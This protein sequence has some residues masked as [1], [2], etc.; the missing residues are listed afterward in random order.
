MGERMKNMIKRLIKVWST[1]MLIGAVCSVSAGAEI[2]QEVNYDFSNHSFTVSGKTDDLLGEV[3]FQVLK[4]DSDEITDENLLYKDQITADGEGKFAFTVD[5]GDSQSGK[6]AGYIMSGDEEKILVNIII[7]EKEDYKRVIE[8]LKQN[9]SSASLMQKFIL[10]EDIDTGLKIYEVLGWD[11]ALFNTL[12]SSDLEPLANYVNNFDENDIKNTSVFNSYMIMAI[13]GKGEVENAHYY[14]EKSYLKFDNVELYEDYLNYS[15]IRPEEKDRQKRQEYFTE[16]LYNAL[17]EEN[18]DG[19]E[20]AVKEALILSETRYAAGAGYLKEIIEKYGDVIDIT[21]NISKDACSK[22]SGEDF[23]DGRALKDE[24]EDAKKTNSGSGSNG[25]GGSSSNKGSSTPGVILNGTGQMANTNKPDIT[26][27]K[28]RFEDID[29]VEWAAEAIYA[30]ADKN[31]INGKGENYFKPD[32]N[33]TREEFVKIIICAM[34]LE[35]ERFSSDIF[36]DV[37]EN[38]WFCKYVN[39]AY[40]KGIVNGIGDGKF[41][42]GLSITRQDIAVMLCN[43]LKYK[44]QQLDT[45]PANFSDNG[46][47]ADYA[48]ESVWALYNLGAVNGVSE[49]EFAPKLCATR[50]QAAK[51]VYGVLNK[52]Q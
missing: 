31:I 18:L 52:L 7:V 15:Y 3:T 5:Y 12:E 35:N 8:E 24:Y 28:L 41:G 34:N 42:T 48:R 6:Y 22:I 37:S 23:S 17:D 1:V 47:I 14:I 4:K 46:D 27:I 40:E 11:V 32:D 16:K 36:S 33:I 38:Q 49:T 25:G 2:S 44:M 39:I 45:T 10:S 20:A 50:A 9:S 19:F 30:L 43:A 21:G 26:P 29:G 51:M 13:A